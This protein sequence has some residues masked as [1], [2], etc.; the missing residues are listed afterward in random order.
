MFVNA[1]FLL[2]VL[3]DMDHAKHLGA[4]RAV[5]AVSRLHQMHLEKQHEAE[6]LMEEFGKAVESQSMSEAEVER[7]SMKLEFAQKQAAKLAELHESV[8][9]KHAEADDALEEFGHAV[10]RN[11]SEQEQLAL[12]KKVET[13]RQLAE[14]EEKAK[15]EQYEKEHGVA[16][17]LEK[18]RQRAAKA[19]ATMRKEAARKPILKSAAKK[20]PSIESPP[21]RRASTEPT[22]RRSK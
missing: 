9:S 11:A 8:E 1:F 13:K 5:Q 20:R 4:L 6:R 22:P 10:G 16:E 7:L 2:A 17:K 19:E 12:S 21:R 3:V 18:M 14:R 15:I